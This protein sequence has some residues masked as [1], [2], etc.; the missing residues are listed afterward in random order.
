MAR[1]TRTALERQAQKILRLAREAGVEESYYFETT[2][3]RYQR[4]LKILGDLEAAMDSADVLVEKEYVKGR[5]NLYANPA[6]VQYNS[7][8]D[9][10]NRTVMALLKILATFKPSQDQPKDELLDYIGR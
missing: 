10:A 1:P 8:A 5:A 6:I 2:F 4:Q 3:L 9:A 7:T